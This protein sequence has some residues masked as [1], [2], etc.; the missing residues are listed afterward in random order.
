M[1]VKELIKKLKKM[2]PEAV[3]CWQAHDQDEHELDGWLQIVQE[4][5]EE[6]LKAEGYPAIVVLGP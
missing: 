2:N 5:C 4:G 6:M 3:V 1:K